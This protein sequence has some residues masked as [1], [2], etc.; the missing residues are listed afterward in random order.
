MA[1][2]CGY[3][4]STTGKLFRPMLLLECALAVGGNVEHVLPAAVGAECGHVASLIHDDIIDRDD[5]R[6]GQL[7][8][9]RKFGTE[10]AI[11]A[12]DALIFD[13][14]AGLA[15]CRAAGATADRVV[16]A[17]HAVAR[18]GI[19]LCRGQTLEAQ[20]TAERWFSVETYLRVAELKTA[21]FFRGA[22]ESGAILGGGSETEIAALAAYGGHLGRAFQI[23]DDLLAFVSDDTTTGKPGDSDLSNGRIT[24]P[25]VLAH[26]HAGAGDRLL[27]ERLLSG[28]DDPPTGL[29]SLRD[30]VERTGGLR[31]A[32]ELATETAQLA[33]RALD[34]IR[35]AQSRDRLHEYAVAVIAR[36]Q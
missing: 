36:Q 3:A 1:E 4:L 24:A 10:D 9:H 21:A 15:E 2:I 7:A 20:V 23:Q 35:P 29:R 22:C 32:N 31:R 11:V 14:F 34:A 8:T 13:L 17:L 27:I 18:S 12:G 28:V 30:V 5:V 16:S 25:V 26:L 19:D 33:R 6:R